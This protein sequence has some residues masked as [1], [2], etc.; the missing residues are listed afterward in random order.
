MCRMD[1]A[2]TNLHLR[3]ADHLDGLIGRLRQNYRIQETNFMN[4]TQFQGYYTK[5]NKY[6]F[7]DFPKTEETQGR[8]KFLKFS[9]FS[10]SH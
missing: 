2:L 1:L 10:T 4:L 5:N 8:M 6:A 9:H 7:R 3:N